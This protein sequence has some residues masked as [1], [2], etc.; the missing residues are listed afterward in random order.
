MS[1]A[2][3]KTANKTTT[4]TTK[5]KTIKTVKKGTKRKT[6]QPSTPQSFLPNIMPFKEWYK[7][8]YMEPEKPVPE[9]Y[10]RELGD[11]LIEHVTN[12]YD[13]LSLIA[14]WTKAGL[15]ASQ[16]RE[17][18][19]QSPY[20]KACIEMAKQILAV[21]REYRMAIKGDIDRAV[22]MATQ[23]YYCSVTRE[24]MEL[25]AELAK[26]KEEDRQQ[27]FHIVRDLGDGKPQTTTWARGNALE[28]HKKKKGENED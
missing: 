16:A 2:T 12:D 23:A 21:K 3:T 4:K 7:F 1:K 9:N 19:K 26:K 5:K 22:V 25:R 27:V 17:W 15:H 18:A 8:H 6:P 13:C 28:E 24:M 10:K 11:A 20:L 14:F